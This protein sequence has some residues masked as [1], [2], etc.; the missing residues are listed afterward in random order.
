MCVLAEPHQFEGGR[1]PCGDLGS[2]G[3]VYLQRKGYILGDRKV[4]KSGLALE[5]DAHIA[6]VR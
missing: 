2:S 6:L 3:A 4:P 5:H 1:P